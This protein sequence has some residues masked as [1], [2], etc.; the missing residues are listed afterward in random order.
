MVRR[1][2]YLVLLLSPTVLFSQEYQ[3]PRYVQGASENDI[4]QHWLQSDK[5]F[6]NGMHLELAHPFLGNGFSRNFLLGFSSATPTYQDYSI[7]IGQDLFTATNTRID[8]IDTA[9]RPYAGILYADYSKVTNDFARGHQMKSHFIIGVQGPTAFGN[10]VQNTVHD[11]INNDSVLGWD[12]QISNGLVLDY[13]VQFNKLLPLNTSV[14]EVVWT[15]RGQVGTIYNYLSTG[16]RFKVGYFRD[17]FLGFQGLYNR[18]YNHAVKE[19]ELEKLKKSRGKAVPK[20]YRDNYAEYY[21]Q[22]LARKLDIHLAL[23]IRARYIFYDGTIQGS[24]IPFQSSAY[25]MEWDD[26]E[27][28]HVFGILELNLNYKAFQLKFR[29]VVENDDVDAGQLFGWGELDILVLF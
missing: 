20:I 10:E 18:R 4:Y 7:S 6:T 23:D 16:I 21:N 14:S 13:G 24:L 3:Q 25:T 15:N 26:Y 1:I 22:R 5:H 28:F 19:E 17:S 11:W 2:Q 9:D 8:Y 12:N 27:H 29:R